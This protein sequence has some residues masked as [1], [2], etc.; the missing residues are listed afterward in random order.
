[1]HPWAALVHTRVRGMLQREIFFKF[2]PYISFPRILI[3]CLSQK[4]RGAANTIISFLCSATLFCTKY[5]KIFLTQVQTTARQIY[6]IFLVGSNPLHFR[7]Q[8]RRRLK[9]DKNKHKETQTSYSRAISPG[10]PPQ[11]SASTHIFHEKWSLLA[12]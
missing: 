1:M 12:R 4:T 2:L 11:Y 8:G 5:T 10:R 7:H 3:S 9:K 6:K